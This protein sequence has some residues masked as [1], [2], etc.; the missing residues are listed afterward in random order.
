MSL[1]GPGLADGCITIW[2]FF[3]LT[4]HVNLPLVDGQ[5]YPNSTYLATAPDVVLTDCHVY[6]ITI[7]QAI[8]D[9]DYLLNFLLTIFERFVFSHILNFLVVI[10]LSVIHKPIRVIIKK[11]VV[12]RY[13]VCGFKIG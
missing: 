8:G 7:L 6:R 5:R 11:L 9:C 3:D 2:Q 4:V 13:F 12:Y 10:F 1:S